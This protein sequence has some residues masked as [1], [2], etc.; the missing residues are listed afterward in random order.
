TGKTWS[1]NRTQTRHKNRRKQETQQEQ[2]RQRIHK[3]GEQDRT[4]NRRRNREER[5]GRTGSRNRS[6]TRSRDRNKRRI[7]GWLR[8]MAEEVRKHSISCA[9]DRSWIKMGGISHA[10]DRSWIRTGSVIHAKIHVK[11]SF[12][13]LCPHAGQFQCKITNIVFEM[14]EKGEVQYRIVSWDTHL[15]DGLGHMQPAGPLYEIN[16]CEGS[17]S[18]LHLPHCETVYEEN[19]MELTVANFINKVETLKPLKVTNTHV[20]IRIQDHT[21]FGLLKNMIHYSSPISAQVL[22]FYKE[23]TIEKIR[24]KLDIHLLPGNVPAEEVQKKH[25][26]STYFE[27][28]SR[29]QLIP[30]R[31]YKASCDPYEP[32]PK[33]NYS[34]STL[35]KMDFLKGLH[36]IRTHEYDLGL[37]VSE[38]HF[39]DK[40]MD[41]LIGRVTSVMEIA[42]C[43]L[44]KKMITDETYDKIHTEKTPQEQMRILIQALRSGGQNMKDEF[45]RILKEKQPFLIKDLETGPSKVVP[46]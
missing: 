7:T 39:V 30:G 40:H 1:R 8:G 11:N 36:L 2:T 46:Q 31:K 38:V 27:T 13:F 17:V 12:H 18:H 28:S 19:Q 22:L 44:S 4:R 20:I 32:Q 24:N 16:C 29:C 6:T 5:S 45:Y 3:P 42:D 25:E 15:L 43:L 34:L 26:G 14:E 9:G 10:R 37:C 33:V 23:M 21:L 35:I 41:K